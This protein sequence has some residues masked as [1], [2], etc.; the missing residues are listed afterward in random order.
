[1]EKPSTLSVLYRNYIFLHAVPKYVSKITSYIRVRL[2]FH[3]NSHVIQDYCN[4]HWFGPPLYKIQLQPAHK[5]ITR[6]RVQIYHTIIYALL[7]LVFTKIY[8]SMTNL[9]ADPLY[10]R[11][12]YLQQALKIGIQSSFNP[13]TD[14]SIFTHVTISLSV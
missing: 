11:Y 12:C 8:V 14:F 6:F 7:K 1:M 9:L 2:D 5:Q 13:N 10:K 4:N 3:S